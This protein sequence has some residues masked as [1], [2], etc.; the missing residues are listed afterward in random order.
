MSHGFSYLVDFPTRVCDT[1]ET[2]IDNFLTNVIS[3]LKFN[4]KGSITNLSDHDAQLSELEHNVNYNNKNI[5]FYKRHFSDN[6]KQLFLRM[7]S[8]ESWFNVYM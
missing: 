5:N 6:N 8:N 1:T 2:Y 3:K 4:V 7:I